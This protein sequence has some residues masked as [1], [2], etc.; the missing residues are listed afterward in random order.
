MRTLP[1]YY[2]A[3]LRRALT[4]MGNINFLIYHSVLLNRGKFCFILVETIFLGFK[5]IS[6][7]QEGVIKIFLLGT[8]SV[9]AQTLIPETSEN[10]LSF[11]V[12]NYLKR[13][14]NQAKVEYDKMCGEI[15]L[16]QTTVT[17]MLLSLLIALI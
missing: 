4:R 1:A 2:A 16:R 3:P 12:S 9:L 10:S 6:R 7:H 15:I 14:K 17:I 5:N 11:S 8:P 13:L